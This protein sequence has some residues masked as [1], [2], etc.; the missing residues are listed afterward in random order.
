MKT[1]VNSTIG[2]FF[3]LALFGAAPAM[4]QMPEITVIDNG[5]AIMAGSSLKDDLDGNKAMPQPMA[6]PAPTAEAVPLP[7]APASIDEIL[8]MDV[9]PANDPTVMPLQA[10]LVVDTPE[11]LSTT[12]Y[13]SSRSSLRGD[14]DK[15]YQ[16]SEDTQVLGW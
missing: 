15:G 6:I 3:A 16:A 4:A 7:A 2:G 1:R 13:V 8:N 10:P 14:L 9:A 5:N 12:P 11:T